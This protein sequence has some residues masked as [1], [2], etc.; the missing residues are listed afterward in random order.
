[1]SRVSGVED[2][3]DLLPESTGVPL[4]VARVHGVPG[5]EAGGEFPPGRTGPNNPEHPS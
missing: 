1:M 4:V 3:E 5:P 2:G